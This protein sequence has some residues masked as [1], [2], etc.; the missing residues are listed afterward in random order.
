MIGRPG[1]SVG[2]RLPGFSTQSFI[3]VGES[4][5]TKC[6]VVT[7]K[8]QFIEAANIMCGYVRKDLA[9]LTEKQLI[10]VIDGFLVLAEE[11]EKRGNPDICRW[12]K[13]LRKFR[14]QLMEASQ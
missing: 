10:H 6:L 3:N 9:M 1:V 2:R 12:A 11:P 7:P 14:V 5:Q 13:R 8:E 4:E